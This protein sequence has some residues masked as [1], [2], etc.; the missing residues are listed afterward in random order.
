MNVTELIERLRYG[1]EHY[2]DRDDAVMTRA[3]D[4]LEAQAREIGLL[5]AAY[6]KEIRLRIEL[7][8]RLAAAER[9]RVRAFATELLRLCDLHEVKQ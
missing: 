8:S 2:D 4:A 9:Q 3:A 1:V 6:N 5:D 7:E